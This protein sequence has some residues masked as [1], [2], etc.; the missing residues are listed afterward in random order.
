M[1]GQWEKLSNK[2]S[3]EFASGRIIHWRK[4][5]FVVVD[6]TVFK[7]IIAREVGKRRRRWRK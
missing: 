7:A 3:V 6:C 4:R 1:I 5:R 2:L